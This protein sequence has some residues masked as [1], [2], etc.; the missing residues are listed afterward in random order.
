MLCSYLS[1]RQQCVFIF[2]VFIS[3]WLPVTSGAP[4]GSILGTLLFSLFNV[5]PVNIRH[6]KI[7]LF[8]DDAKCVKNVKSVASCIELQGDTDSSF[9]WSQKWRIIFNISKCFIITFTRLKNPVFFNYSMD[10]VTLKRVTEVQDLGICLTHPFNRTFMSRILY[11]KQKHLGWHAPLHTK[12]I[13]YRSLVRSNLEYCSPLSGGSNQKYTKSIEIMQRPMTRYLCGYSK[14]E[15][16][17]RLLSVVS[18]IYD[19]LVPN[20]MQPWLDNHSHPLKGANRQLTSSKETSLVL[21]E[22]ISYNTERGSTV[23]VALLDVKKAF[24]TVWIAGLIYEL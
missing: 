23:Y 11:Q 24:A 5:L 9:S 12:L 22:A 6:S 8:A 3:A 2:W 18:K 7:A 1:K 13:L 17:E 4:Q 19:T 15:Y 21:Q 16:I 14:A 10:R 20:L